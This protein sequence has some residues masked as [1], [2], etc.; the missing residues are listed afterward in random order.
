MAGSAVAAPTIMV[1]NTNDS[2]PGSLR[3]TIADAPTGA[4]ISVPAGTYS[5]TGGEIA[6]AKSL[7]VNGAGAS[8][9]T[10]QAGA[11]SRLFHTSGASSTIT[12]S[13]MTIR[14]GNPQ[15]VATNKVSGGGVLNDD[16][17]LTLSNDVITSNHADADGIGP[18]GSG[19]VAS[20]GGV[21]NGNDGT[22]RL[23][24]TSVLGN[25]AS[26][27]GSSGHAGG[28]AEGGGAA[29]D[30]ALTVLDSAFS[31][32]QANALGGQGPANANQFG[33]IAQGGGLSTAPDHPV[34]IAAT[35]FDH[36]V[37]DASG[38]PG[39]GGGIS[40][41]GGAFLDTNEVPVSNVNDTYFGDIARTSRGGSSSGGAMFAGSN[42]GDLSLTNMT[43]TNGTALG[44]LTNEGGDLSFGGNAPVSIENSVISVGVADVGSENCSGGGTS[45]GHNIDSLDECSFHAPGDLINANA[46]LGPLEDNGGPAPT[47][48]LG[49]G[50][51]AIDHGAPGDCPATDER[52]ALRPAGAGC[53]I[54]AFEV[55]TPGATT[56][57]ASS[58]AA[59]SAL[60]VGH[61][62]NPDVASATAFFEYGRTNA[63][64]G[65]TPDTAVGAAVRAASVSAPVARLAP[66]TTY[67]FRV[68][69]V[70]AV[71][72]A[73]GADQTFRTAPNP[74]IIAKLAIR[75][76]VLSSTRAAT[77]SYTDT[78]RATTA[79]VEQRMSAGRLDH[80]SC[81][82]VTSR[83][84]SLKHCVRW[85][86]V[87]RRFTHA[88][89]RGT[90][91]VRLTTRSSGRS[92]ASG[93]YRLV[94][95]PRAGGLT[96]NSLHA[97]FRIVGG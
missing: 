88:D 49:A 38:G 70:N 41:G 79:F 15:V 4:T 97:G 61:V 96:G 2:G 1:T 90:N 31:D 30:G 33:S 53:D 59:S 48:G 78:E 25:T 77:V 94:A 93:T 86:S 17:T 57:Q 20:G 56:G 85:V 92:L 91:R 80:G 65:R 62:F 76:G 13:G 67:H 66:A 10:V 95:T 21:F 42:G 27:V 72:T 71:G 29:G 16:A 44:G 75:P 8:S 19:G 69:V 60:L 55:A 84:R 46:V 5:L 83:N 24:H 7:T 36:N 43:I 28:I 47:L 3:Q 6:I 63:Y 58:V 82:A 74:P 9:A 11:P 54:G 23:L 51:P 64:G 87:G 22:L 39:G 12:I 37:A 45:L 14:D 52:G 34:S 26:A 35:T 18:N 50:S 40:E 73:F 68:V 81:I 89:V 32:N